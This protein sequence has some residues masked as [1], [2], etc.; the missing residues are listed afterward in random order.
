MASTYLCTLDG[1]GGFQKHVVIKMLDP[2]RLEDP[3][4]FEMFLDEARLW[5][6]FNHPN[7]PQA[8]ELGDHNGIPYIV[9][10]YVPGP[11]LHMLSRKLIMPTAVDLCFIAHIGAEIARALD[12]AYFGTGGDGVR[13]GVVHRDVTLTNMLVSTSGQA[14]L[15]D[16]GI[17]LADG[18]LSRTE[19]GTLK[20][21]IQYMAP[22]QLLDKPADHRTDIFQLGITLYHL[23]TGRPAFGSTSRSQTAL[24]KAR[25]EGHIT[26]VVVAA[27]MCPPELAEIVEQCIHPQPERRFARA[28]LLAEALEGFATSMMGHKIE[29]NEVAIWIHQMFPNQEWSASARQTP[30]NLTGSMHNTPSPMTTSVRVAE[31][32]AR[33]RTIAAIATIVVSGLLLMGAIVV[34]VGAAFVAVQMELQKE[35]AADG[36]MVEPAVDPNYTA[37]VFVDEAELMLE[38]DRDADAAAFLLKAQ[39]SNPTNPEVV[40][41]LVRVKSELEDR[42]LIASA[43]Q[44]LAAG[45]LAAAAERARSLLDRQPTHQ[46]ALA[47][48]EQVAAA[49]AAAEPADRPRTPP[50]KGRLVVSTEPPAQV[51]VDDRPYGTTPL[52][53]D[54]A[55]GSHDVHVRLAGYRAVKRSVTIPSNDSVELDVVLDSIEPP[56]PTDVPPASA[57][58]VPA[59]AT[60]ALPVPESIAPPVEVGRAMVVVPP[61]TPSAPE[62]PAPE[63]GKPDSPSPLDMVSDVPVS[64]QALILLRALAFDTKLRARSGDKLVI[65][66]LYIDP[67]TRKRAFRMNSGFET[68]TGRV[69]GMPLSIVALEYTTQSALSASISELG[70][71]VLYV[72]TGLGAQVAAISA[73]ARSASVL[74]IGAEPT[75]VSSG[76]S[77]GVF[78]LRGEPK[79]AFNKS[80]AAAAGAAFEGELLDVAVR[81]D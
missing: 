59:P 36:P 68:Y 71:D 54:L 25:M 34:G 6:K 10:E 63:V 9:M 64:Q 47:V 39:E 41:R 48:L 69:Q 37:T 8:F 50:G 55:P 23:V 44:A 13:L 7:I 16:F 53:L 24:W 20:G 62:L 11:T 42:L 80:A 38:L 46:G 22:E 77:L 75:Y 65:A 61:P 60:G 3:G 51:F 19:I 58:P 40:V 12:Y 72:P 2:D 30:S 17:S 27:P 15:I 1:V 74:T 5:A 52:T 4:Y 57:S 76:L 35:N 31:P 56:S 79:L 26:P 43:H 18:R 66:S 45:D 67:T 33:R 14:K 73:T 81:M 28:S 70:I 21:R 78:T 29:A 32:V 49:D